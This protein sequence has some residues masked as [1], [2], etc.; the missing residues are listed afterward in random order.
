MQV[1]KILMVQRYK[2]LKKKLFTPHNQKTHNNKN[3]SLHL[4]KVLSLVEQMT[5]QK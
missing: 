1:E 2:V 4:S 5:V 3:N